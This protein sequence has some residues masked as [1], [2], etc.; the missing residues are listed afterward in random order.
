[1]TSNTAKVD[2][3]PSTNVS[4]TI[5]WHKMTAGAVTIKSD[6]DDKAP[7]SLTKTTP[8]E[9]RDATAPKTSS[10]TTAETNE[11]TARNMSNTTNQAA[12]STAKTSSCKN[13]LI[14]WGTLPRP[15][16]TQQEGTGF[17]SPPRHGRLNLIQ[18]YYTVFCLWGIQEWQLG[19]V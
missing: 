1:M 11:G 19:S 7:I 17:V 9:I 18:P 5:L 16:N 15:I 3:V 4:D 13:H 10:W 14:L 12:V 6:E 2:E 8:V